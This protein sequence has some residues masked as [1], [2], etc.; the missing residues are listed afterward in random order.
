MRAGPGRHDGPHVFVEDVGDP[1]LADED[2]HHLSRVLRVRQGDPL[3]V[4]DGSGRWRR[5]GFGDPL[6]P[7]SRIER[8]ERRTPMLMV[9]FALVKGDRPELVTQKLTEMGVDVIA[10]F[11]AERSVVRWDGLK[12]ARNLERLR[13]VAREA[14]MQARR[15][16][17]PEVR[18]LSTLPR[19]AESWHGVALADPD[20]DPL[21]CAV[22]GVLIGPEG[23]WTPA[24]LETA[25]AR[26]CL[27]DHV[28]RAETAAIVAG[29]HLTAVRGGL[30]SCG[31]D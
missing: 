27:A 26:V 20:G 8:I 14:A 16:W 6:E 11:A 30:L 24:E 15:C 10:P 2:R 12:A 3:T 1:V 17:L 25:G 19:V 23:G 28:L 22:T 29:A 18:P 9:G 5:C 21:T 7:R 13:R 4:S 31:D